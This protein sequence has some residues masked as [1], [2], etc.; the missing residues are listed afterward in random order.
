MDRGALEDADTQSIETKQPCSRRGQATRSR[1]SE[2]DKSEVRGTKL[3]AGCCDLQSSIT[4][5]S[6]EVAGVVWVNRCGVSFASTGMQTARGDDRPGLGTS[7]SVLPGVKGS[8]PAERLQLAAQRV[9]AAVRLVRSR[10][11]WLQGPR[12]A[13]TGRDPCRWPGVRWVAQGTIRYR[14]AASGQD[15]ENQQ[16][17]DSQDRPCLVS[18]VHWST[19]AGGAATLDRCEGAC[20][21]CVPGCVSAL[22]QSPA[23]VREAVPQLSLPGTLQQGTRGWA[24]GA[25]HSTGCGI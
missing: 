15:G 8:P 6:L 11:G 5:S 20:V 16:W 7:T 3:A 12:C 9:M 25:Y 13:G 10:C 24:E 2:T 1:G 18:L 23:P 22:S 19:G 17:R 14:K 4:W 21:R